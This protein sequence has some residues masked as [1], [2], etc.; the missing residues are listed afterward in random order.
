MAALLLPLALLAQ[1]PPT[2]SPADAVKGLPA[3]AS[4]ADYQGQAKAGKISIGADFDGHSVP[5]EDGI[6][7]S[8]DYV[9]FEVSVFGPAG[10]SLKLSTED[11]SLRVNGKKNTSPAQSYTVVFSSLKDPNWQ[12]PVPVEKS[13][14]SK[15]GIT[16]GGGG[17]GNSN[18]PPPP[19][20]KMSFPERRAMEQKVQ[21]AALREGDRPLPSAGLVFFPFRG[22]PKSSDTFEL[23]YSGPAGKASITLQ[24]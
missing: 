17:E 1:A 8:E 11:F 9:V 3:R 12:P 15:G 22:K 19:P 16:G 10:E 13:K 18:D 24:P 14:S 5:T 23:I 20:P 6:F 2:P 7:S 21:K 4:A